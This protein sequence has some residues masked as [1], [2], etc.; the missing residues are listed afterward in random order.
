MIP[1]I[2]PTSQGNN[3][4]MTPRLRL[5]R[6]QEEGY[7]DEEIDLMI[8]EQLERNLERTKYWREILLLIHAQYDI[9]S[10]SPG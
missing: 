8:E 6:W 2:P 4:Y 5:L 1:Y 9:N 3:V 10:S 7:S